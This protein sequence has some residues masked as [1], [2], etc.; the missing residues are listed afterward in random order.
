M[1]LGILV[2]LRLPMI[3]R[4]PCRKAVWLAGHWAGPGPAQVDVST[5]IRPFP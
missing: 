4:M 5:G 1:I 3:Y 2:R